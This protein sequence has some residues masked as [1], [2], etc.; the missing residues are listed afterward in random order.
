MCSIIEDIYQ[1]GREEGRREGRE[2]GRAEGRLNSLF[3]TIR[4]LRLTTGWSDEE[5]VDKFSISDEDW[6]LFLASN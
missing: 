3:D 4:K 1:E 6:K 2:E 5:I